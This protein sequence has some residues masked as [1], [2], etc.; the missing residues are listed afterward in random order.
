MRENITSQS[1]LFENSFVRP[2]FAAFDQPAS[3]SDGGALLLKVADERLRLTSVVAGAL[4]HER[5][6]SKIKHSLRNVVQQ[7]VYGICN[8]YEDVNDAARLRDDPTHQLLLG[9]S[10]GAG[11]ELASQPTISRLENAFGEGHVKAA[12][13][14]F[15]GA[16]LERHQRRLRQRAKRIII[17][18]DA[19]CDAAHGQQQGALF[20]GFYGDH[21]F[22][23]LAAF[24]MFDD[25]SEQYLLAALL[26]PGNAGNAQVLAFLKS[27]IERVRATFPKAELPGGE[28]R[29]FTLETTPITPRTGPATPDGQALRTGRHQATEYR[30]A[31]PRKA[32]AEK[33]LMNRPG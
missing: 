14:A 12:G 32:S 9:H 11:S 23:P 33:P 5:E 19:T 4:P 13:E 3:S 20:S 16:V 30:A 8:G 24:A 29:L 28:A 21:G 6:A 26:R 18:V 27:V 31:V 10:P 22:L 7:R 1:V 25:E 15:T 2:V 17:D